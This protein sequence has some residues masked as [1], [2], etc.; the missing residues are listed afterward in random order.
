M[1]PPAVRVAGPAAGGSAA[2]VGLAPAL[3]MDMAYLGLAGSIGLAMQNA[4]ACQQR[5]Q[6]LTGA[7]IAQV[8][9]L[10]LAQGGKSS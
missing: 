5:S 8:L 10:I 2:A 3:A 9:A 7:A 1:A 6:A 4:V